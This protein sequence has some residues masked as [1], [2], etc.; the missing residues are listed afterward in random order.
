M[1]T[2]ILL[3]LA[4][5]G[6]ISLSAGLEPWQDPQVNEINRLPARALL[7]PCETEDLAIGVANG[8]KSKYDSRYVMSLNREWGFKWKAS[9]SDAWQNQ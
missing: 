4:T 3:A 2:I 5:T 7:V 8:E 1:K 6:A 9:P